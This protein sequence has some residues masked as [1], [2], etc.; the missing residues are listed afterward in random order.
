MPAADRERPWE[1]LSSGQQCSEETEGGIQAIGSV[2]Y[3]GKVCLLASQA[4]LFPWPLNQDLPG[5]L[6]L[7]RSELLSR[8]S[9]WNLFP[10]GEQEGGFSPVE[11]VIRF[12]RQ[13]RRE[14]GECDSYTQKYRSLSEIEESL[15]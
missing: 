5:R 10:A 6:S 1:H 13:G 12:G 11:R 7:F 3:K 4:P 2:S 8:R 14:P 9:K 15:G